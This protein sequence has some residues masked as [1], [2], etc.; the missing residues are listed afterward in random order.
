MVFRPFA[1]EPIAK[2]QLPIA[3]PSGSMRSFVVNYHFRRPPPQAVVCH[4]RPFDRIGGRS[5]RPHHPNSR[6]I[7]VI[8]WLS[9]PALAEVDHSGISA[10][11]LSDGLSQPLNRRGDQNQMHVVRHQ[12]VGPDAN[13]KLTAPMGQQR[14]I[15]L[16]VLIAEKRLH[17]TIPALGHMMRPPRR[18]YSRYPWHESSLNHTTDQHKQII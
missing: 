10:V 15:L 11:D 5:L 18:H 6:I 17:A 4:H 12:A 7:S 1:V 9:P 8:V 16:I 13:A 2:N 14:K 3:R